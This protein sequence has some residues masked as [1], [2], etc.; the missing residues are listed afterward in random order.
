MHPRGLVL[1]PSAGEMMWRFCPEREEVHKSRDLEIYPQ[2]NLLYLKQSINK[3]KEEESGMSIQTIRQKV[4][5]V[6]ERTME[7]HS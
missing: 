3:I 5:S 1:I 4:I 6:P 2:R 7:R